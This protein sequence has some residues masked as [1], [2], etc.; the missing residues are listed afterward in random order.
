[1]LPSRRVAR[2]LDT[3]GEKLQ[4]PSLTENKEFKTFKLLIDFPRI[5]LN[6]FKFVETKNNSLVKNIYVVTHF[7]A[8]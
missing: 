3:Q 8:P 4:G 5:Y 2:F 1:L 6:H 7:A